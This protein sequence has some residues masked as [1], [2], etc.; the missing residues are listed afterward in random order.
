[1]LD[2]LMDP[3]M[4]RGNQ[5]DQNNPKSKIKYMSRD[6]FQVP[7]FRNICDFQQNS[8]S[9]YTA[10]GGRVKGKVEQSAEYTKGDKTPHD[11]DDEFDSQLNGMFGDSISSGIQ[12]EKCKPGKSK[13]INVNRTPIGTFSRGGFGK[14]LDRFS[15][16][17]TGIN[18]RRETISDQEMDRF[19]FT[20]RKYQDAH[21]GSFPES[22][23]SRLGNKKVIN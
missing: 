11:L 12:D 22:I 2:I 3:M 1:M 18:T 19:H 4:K 23:S 20:Y 21:W 9:M 16:L 6:S 7:L 8:D 14:D 13:F 15:E 10:N 5:P 17:K